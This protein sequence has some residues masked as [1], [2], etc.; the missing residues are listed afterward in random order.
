MVR[1]IRENQVLRLST[2]YLV[3]LNSS[4]IFVKI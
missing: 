1:M 2:F 3:M 4:F